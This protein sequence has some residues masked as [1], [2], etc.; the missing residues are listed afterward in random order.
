MGLYRSA[1]LMGLP[2]EAMQSRS[3]QPEVENQPHWLKNLCSRQTAVFFG[4]QMT[5][6]TTVEGD[7]N[8]LSVACACT[9]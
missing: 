4:E 3:K 1:A 7:R 5:V 6:A 8:E 9:Q 2:L